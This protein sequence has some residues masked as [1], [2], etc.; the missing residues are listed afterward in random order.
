MRSLGPKR[1]KAQ[2]NGLT[3]PQ[4]EAAFR[5][6]R[7]E[8]S[9]TPARA[10]RR[11]IAEVGE[12]LIA[13]KK[14]AGRKRTTIEGYDYWLRIHIVPCFG[15]QDVAKIIPDDVRRFDAELEAK[16]LAPKCRADALGNLHS[17]IE[18]A[19]TEAGP[20]ARTHVSASLSPSRPTRTRTSTT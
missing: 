1:S 18:Y 14:A 15:A 10:Q 6:L 13:A 4:A 12:A 17:L 19:M 16:G 7:E 2:P 9:A 11:T 5:K 3:Q 8:A 20:P